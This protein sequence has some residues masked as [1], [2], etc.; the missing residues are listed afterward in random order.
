MMSLKPSILQLIAALLVPAPA[1]Y[2]ERGAPPQSRSDEQNQA[3]EKMLAG[4]FMPFAIIKR[5]VEQE[6]KTSSKDFLGS[7]LLA[8]ST[9][10]RLKDVKDDR[11]IWFD[12]DGRTG[13]IKAR[14]R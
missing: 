7:E 3:R 6:T 8:N 14:S 4:Q 1:A 10:Y 5:R 11:V 9:G 13:D 2:A 12:V